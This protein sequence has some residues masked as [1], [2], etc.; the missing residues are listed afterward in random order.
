MIP[1][2]MRYRVLLI[3]F[4]L[5]LA[6]E[7]F[8]QIPTAGGGVEEF[9]RIHPPY[10]AAAQ[11]G[12]VSP[13]FLSPLPLSRLKREFDRKGGG[14]PRT[15][16]AAFDRFEEGYLAF[17]GRS[18]DRALSAFREVGEILPTYTA[19]FNEGCAALAA[20]DRQG[21]KDAW[22]RAISLD[23]RGGEARYNLGL[24]LYPVED[25]LEGTTLLKGAIER[26]EEPARGDAAFHLAV[27][28]SVA[29]RQTGSPE[30]ARSALDA[31][32]ALLAATPQEK[33]PLRHA[34]LRLHE[35]AAL[36]LLFPKASALER[37]EEDLRIALGHFSAEAYP[38]YFARCH[39]Q[40]GEIETLRFQQTGR[41]EH[42]E[43]AIE[44]F[45]RIEPL[46]PAERFPPFRAALA[47]RIG[48]LLLHRPPVDGED[49]SPLTDAL[50]AYEKALSLLPEDTP[51]RVRA[52]LLFARGSVESVLATKPQPAPV[53][54][55]GCGGDDDTRA[56]RR[57]ERLASAI[58]ALEAAARLLEND[59]VQLAWTCRTLG[60]SYA[61]ILDRGFFDRTRKRNLD[62]ALTWYRKAHD[63]FE[64]F[65]AE[66]A[67]RIAEEIARI[68][69]ERRSL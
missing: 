67:R 64:G 68:E 56:R 26:L 2:A 13:G 24:L 33:A 41:V 49:T 35:A 66:V 57:T 31:L 53:S 17:F 39:H 18:F 55:G 28:R 16:A 34:L 15:R 46:Y 32:R 23:P 62:A 21:A 52:H 51:P 27:A 4:L 12:N 58:D 9:R 25:P 6:Q 63:L 61:A 40:L 38:S 44:H 59:P 50:G 11:E 10:L 60:A 37:A 36:S 54:S 14:D 48:D 20:G 43:A 7:S 45:R 19:A 3:A 29:A 65:D 42:L 69:A 1:R 5:F 47:W 8:G 22:K 30:R